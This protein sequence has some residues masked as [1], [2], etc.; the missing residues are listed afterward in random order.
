MSLVQAAFHTSREFFRKAEQHDPTEWREATAKT[1]G[2]S[3]GFG[4]VHPAVDSG[5]APWQQVS[6]E[7]A[8]P[9]ARASRPRQAKERRRIQASCGGLL[10]EGRRLY[11][12]AAGAS[13]ASLERL[14]QGSSATAAIVMLAVLVVLVCLLAMGLIVFTKGPGVSRLLEAPPSMAQGG[15]AALRSDPS[16]VKRGVP[17]P[18]AACSVKAA[19]PALGVPSPSPSA[20]HVPSPS[21]PEAEQD[22]FCQELVVPPGFECIL[23]LPSRSLGQGPF[24]VTDTSGITVL[25]V[26]PRPDPVGSTASLGGQVLHASP[27]LQR[28]VLKT[29]YGDL[30][31]QCGRVPGR[32][33]VKEFHLLRAGGDYFGKLTSSEGSNQHVLATKTG[34][35]LNFHG[36]IKD[37]AIDVTDDSGGFFATT[38]VQA[39]HCYKLRVA[40]LVDVGLVL[41]GLVCIGHLKQ[42]QA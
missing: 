32:T 31:A 11:S 6:E 7:A 41:C 4:L 15:R 22:G 33:D 37:R 24:N 9:A 2:S 42:G 30:L 19:S 18:K 16:S 14:V 38:E 5:Q 40:P 13:A 8:L 21:S 25:S 26:E 20:M 34:I 39:L 27:E 12:K 29:K 3:P 28:F 10:Q 23:L 17:A 35:K 36:S 1:H